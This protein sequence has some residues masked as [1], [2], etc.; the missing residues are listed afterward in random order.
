MRCKSEIP[1]PEQFSVWIWSN[2]ALEFLQPSFIN[3]FFIKRDKGQ[4]YQ[5]IKIVLTYFHEPL[6]NPSNNNR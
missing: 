6:H 2:Y 1:L 3:S 4:T 5:E